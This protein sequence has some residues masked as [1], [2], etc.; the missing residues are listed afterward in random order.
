MIFDILNCLYDG[1]VRYI[2]RRETVGN[3]IK[4]RAL[5]SKTFR[6]NELNGKVKKSDTIFI[7][8]GS[9]SINDIAEEQWK[10]VEEHDS[11]GMNWWPLHHFVPTYYYTNYPRDPVAFDHFKKILSP[12]LKKYN[13]TIFFLSSNRAVR[14]GIHPKVIPEL[15]PKNPNCCFYKYPKQIKP[16]LDGNFCKEDFKDSLYYRGGLTIILELINRIGGYKNIVLMGIDLRNS[17]HFYDSYPEMQWQFGTGYS[18][19]LKDKE[20]IVHATNVKK[21][22]KEPVAK[23][24][25]ALNELYY[26]PLG[27]NLFVGSKNSILSEKTPIYSFSF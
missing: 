14:R 27:I 17:V 1:K 23:Y 24:L 22:K 11:I 26:K 5:P 16:I 3:W 13:K 10:Y 4:N 21:G 25:F 12:K 6:I 20:S 9:E 7:L 15:F 19:P 8:G 18:N 2:S